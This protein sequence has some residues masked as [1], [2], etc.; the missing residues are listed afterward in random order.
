MEN[1]DH[2]FY[3]Y[4]SLKAGEGLHLQKSVMIL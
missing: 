1:K 3:I 2:N 4:R